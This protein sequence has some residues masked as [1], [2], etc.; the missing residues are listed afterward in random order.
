[1]NPPTM[2]DISG[3]VS[4][5]V[6]KNKPFYKRKRYVIPAIAVVLILLGIAFGG[7]GAGEFETQV[8]ELTSV[9]QIVSETGNVT[10]G[11]D[12]SLAFARSGRVALVNV[13]KGDHVQRGQVLASLNL[14][15]LN[16]ELKQ[17]LAALELE[18][19]TV[20]QNELILRN[21]RQ[22]LMN[23]VTDAYVAADDIV[24]GTIDQ[25]FENPESS[26]PS[27]G[28]SISQ[29]GTDYYISA[30]GTLENQIDAVRAAVEDQLKEL[31]TVIFTVQPEDAELVSGQTE[32]VLQ[33]VQRLLSLIA[34]A[35]NEYVGGDTTVQVIYE[36]F[37]SDI[38]AARTRVGTEVGSLRTAMQSVE[39][40]RTTI[41]ITGQNSSMVSLQDI[42]IDQAQAKVDAIQSAIN[43]A[44]IIA[45]ISGIITD[46]AVNVGEVTGTS[47]P[48]IS[49]ISDNDLEISV[50][51]LEDDIEFVDAGDIADVT[52]DAY[53][54]EVFRAE[55]I[56]VS[57]KAEQEEGSP[58]FEVVLAFFE[59]DPRIRAGLSADVDIVTELREGVIAI[60][61]RSVIEEDGMRFVRVLVDE[62]TYRRQ[63]VELGLR[64][65]GGVTEVTDGLQAGMEV[66]TFIDDSALDRLMLVE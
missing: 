26:R 2:E 20:Q 35:L 61:S 29:S 19:G 56:F 34:S 38:S 7:N 48:A 52:F 24:Q 43:D 13:D 14:G 5:P 21:A 25:L 6:R 47:T 65:E 30:S 41:E 23:A 36:G 50:D 31:E 17:A 3:D 28:I 9:T 60:P 59:N 62:R 18:R 54:N 58:A 51:I 10:S 33:D 44:L 42:R 57:P 37:K 1:M 39:N 45:P 12:I 63:P 8:V 27:F 32:D 66:I 64:G 49:L 15:S 22:N 40:A 55:V 4:E 16:A 11:Q 53:E 46:V